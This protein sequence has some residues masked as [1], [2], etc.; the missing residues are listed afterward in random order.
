MGSTVPKLSRHQVFML[1]TVKIN[2][3][4]QSKESVIACMFTLNVNNTVSTLLLLQEEDEHHIKS[5][6]RI[7]L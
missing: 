7:F 6:A 3:I 4:K 5:E 1:A 2:V